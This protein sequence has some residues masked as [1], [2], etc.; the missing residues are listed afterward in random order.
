MRN[1]IEDLQI[2]I[3]SLPL[4]YLILSDTKLDKY[5]PDEIEINMMV[6]LLSLLEGGLFQK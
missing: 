1:K 4:D 3:P 5:G 2:I 6:V